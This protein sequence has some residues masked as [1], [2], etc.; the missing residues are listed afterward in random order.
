MFYLFQKEIAQL[1][2]ELSLSGPR[3]KELQREIDL[4]KEEICIVM[5]N[6]Q[7]NLKKKLGT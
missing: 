3:V 1:K 5:A 2:K 6:M 7:L 4:A